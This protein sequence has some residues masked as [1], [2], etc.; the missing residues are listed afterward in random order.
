[1]RSNWRGIGGGSETEL[2]ISNYV[3]ALRAEAAGSADTTRA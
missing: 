1:M 3:T 2:A